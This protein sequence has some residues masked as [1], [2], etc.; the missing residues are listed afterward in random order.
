[1]ITVARS[2]Q[3]NDLFVPLFRPK[4]LGGVS[5]CQ[6]LLHGCMDWLSWHALFFDGE[7]LYESG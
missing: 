5:S 3:S 4:D 2:F 1:M 7:T 6:G